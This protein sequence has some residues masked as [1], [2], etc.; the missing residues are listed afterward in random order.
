[1]AQ[2]HGSAR[3]GE[4]LLQLDGVDLG[5]GDRVILPGVSL[6]LHRGERVAL[7]GRSGAGKSTLLAALRER[8]AD[9]AAWCPQADALVPSLSAYHNIYMGR[10]HAFS[11][12]QNL[13]NLVRPRRAAWHDISALAAELGLAGLLLRRVDSLSGGQRQRV[14]IGRALY[15]NREVF[16][17][18][19]PVS[20]VDPRQASQLLALTEQRHSTSVVALHQRELALQ[21]FQRIIAIADGRIVFDAPVDTL[22]RSR[23]DALYAQR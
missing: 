8:L 7:L 18:D 5:Y 12:W 4:A 16:V 17:G 1:M 2:D 9:S 22:D 19:E 6:T 23:I 11:R 10:L 15:Q 14:M 3:A 21:H 20:S 13:V